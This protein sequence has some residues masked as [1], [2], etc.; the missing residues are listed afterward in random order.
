MTDSL[1]P[2]LS[3]KG[4]VIIGAQDRTP[5]VREAVKC[6]DDGILKDV[7]KAAEGK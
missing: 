2:F 7:R 3:P 5:C 4:I 6:D 1:T